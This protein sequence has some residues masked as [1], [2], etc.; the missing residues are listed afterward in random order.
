MDL[1][2]ICTGESAT[3]KCKQCDCGVDEFTFYDGQLKYGDFC[4]M[5]CE[6]VYG[7]MFHEVESKLQKKSTKSEKS[8]AIKSS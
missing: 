8:S 4:C 7:C 5:S 1:L 6:Y 2:S 3:I